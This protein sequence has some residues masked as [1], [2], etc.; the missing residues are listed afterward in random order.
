MIPTVIYIQSQNQG[1]I[2]RKVYGIIIIQTENERPAGYMMV[3]DGITWMK[4][5]M[6]PCLRE[7]EKRLIMHRI[8][9]RQA[10]QC[11]TAGF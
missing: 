1:G 6:E 9:L 10:G 7:L 2:K 5:I 4:I 8:G 3:T 11:R